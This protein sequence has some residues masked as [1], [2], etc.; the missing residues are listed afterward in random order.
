[1]S[2]WADIARSIADATERDFIIENRQSIGGGCIN[3]AYHVTGSGRVFFVKINAPRKHDMF[4][5]ESA[6]L[7]EIA[8]SDVIRVPRPVCDGRNNEASWL[9]LEHV[10]LGGRRDGRKLGTQLA[11][12]HRITAEKFGWKRGNTIGATAQINTWCDDWLEFWREQRLGFQ[13][14]LAA[15][16]GAPRRLLAQ[17]E[18]LL[19]DCA[20]LLAGR[21]VEPSL[22]HGDLWG[23]NAGFDHDG[24]P[25]LFDPAV[26]YGDRD[27][28]LAMTELFGGFDSDFYA[29]Y[30][31]VHPRVD[32]YPVRRTLY[33]LYHIL[34]H[35]NL[36]GGNYAQQAEAM[37]G[38][39]LAELR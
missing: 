25:V 37:V 22:L 26:Y 30:D 14:Q 1:M 24:N 17:G 4:I 9:V 39:L 36:F 11:A 38:E 34:N 19:A 6:G 3:T 10:E 12:M 21:R 23:G 15:K 27:T 7:R 20:P 28:D 13:L 18:R 35:F 31:E 32:G 33:N 5:A 29:A 16:N 8:Q 2:P